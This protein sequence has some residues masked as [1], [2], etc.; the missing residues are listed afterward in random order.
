MNIRKKILFQQAMSIKSWAKTK[1]NGG[2]RVK[3]WPIVAWRQL[4]SRKKVKQKYK[5]IACKAKFFPPY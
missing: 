1:K 2:G 4:Q 3:S 5:D